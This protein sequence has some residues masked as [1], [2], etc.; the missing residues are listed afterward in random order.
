MTETVYGVVHACVLSRVR[1][2]GTPWAVARQAP[3]SM[4]FS[5]RVYWS[6][7]PFPSPGDLPHPGIKSVSL[8]SPAL[9][10][11]F[12]TTAPPGNPL[13]FLNGSLSNARDAIMI[14]KILRLFRSDLAFIFL[15]MWICSVT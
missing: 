4:G 10:G 7:V 2:F 5:R 3:P 11:G 1:L 8:M 15:T 6:G 12:F 13:S 14:N 9:A